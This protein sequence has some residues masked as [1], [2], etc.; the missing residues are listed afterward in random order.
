VNTCKDFVR[1]AAIPQ[2]FSILKKTPQKPGSNDKKAV[3]D[4]AAEI[5]SL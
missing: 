5:V 3:L 2:K 4:A 1:F